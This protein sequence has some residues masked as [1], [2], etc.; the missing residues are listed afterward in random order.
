MNYEHVITGTFLERPN[1]FIAKVQ[2]GQ[3]IVTVHVK[4]TGRCKEIL[5]PGAKV[6]FSASDS[7]NRKTPYDLVAAYKGDL[8]IN[9]DS[10]APNAAFKDYIASSGCFGPRPQ[11][12][13]EKFHG[14]SRFDFY[15]ESDGRKIFAEVKGVT[16][17]N[18]G[19]CMFPDAPTERG[20]KISEVWRNA[21]GKRIRG[22]RGDDRADEGDEGVYPQLL[23]AQGVRGGHGACG[24]VGGGCHGPGVRR[25]RG[26]HDRERPPDPPFV[27]PI[28]GNPAPS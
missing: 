7:P 10:Q 16:L 17:E 2:F 15:V 3:Q 27:P 28:A 4:N 1:R 14:D 13:P 12:Y 20:L 22:L 24:E 6:V 26:L 25:R 18:E 5:V 19:V 9:I 23:H 8:L 11:I 21:S